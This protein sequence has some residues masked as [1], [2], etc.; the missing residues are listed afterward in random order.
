MRAHACK[1]THT[2]FDWLVELTSLT[3]CLTLKSVLANISAAA[4]TRKQNTVTFEVFVLWLCNQW[5]YTGDL[6]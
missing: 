3:C 1:H 4:N 5:Y 6:K 2:G